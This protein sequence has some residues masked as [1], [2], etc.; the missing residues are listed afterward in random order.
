[1]KLNSEPQLVGSKL[2]VNGMS[3]TFNIS[4]FKNGSESTCYSA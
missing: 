1:M 4:F 3:L 2:S